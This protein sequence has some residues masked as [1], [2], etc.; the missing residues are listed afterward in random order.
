MMR[1]IMFIMII[2]IIVKSS[3]GVEREIAELKL[4]ILLKHKHFS[5]NFYRSMLL[6]IKRY[7]A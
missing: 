1:V 5:V 4:N 6:C 3:S 2:K 7:E